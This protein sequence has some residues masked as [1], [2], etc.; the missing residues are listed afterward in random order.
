MIT[1]SPCVFGGW[2]SE[3]R[4][5]R[6]RKREARARTRDA[7]LMARI[8]KLNPDMTLLQIDRVAE[9]T[10]T[11]YLASIGLI[12]KYLRRTSLPKM[13]APAWD[14]VLVKYIDYLFGAG[15]DMGDATRAMSSVAWIQPHLISSHKVAFPLNSSAA[16]G[17]NRVH[18][19]LLF[20]SA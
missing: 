15:A 17:W 3:R 7:K 9:G 16:S 8:Q 20:P 12:L 19:A 11:R 1:T 13:A 4:Q 5:I 2:G 18:S 10:Q 6:L 14:R